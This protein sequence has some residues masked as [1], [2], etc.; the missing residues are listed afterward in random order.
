[1]G[2]FCKQRECWFGVG[3][4]GRSIELLFFYALLYTYS[5]LEEVG[6]E[7]DAPAALPLP[8]NGHNARLE[9]FEMGDF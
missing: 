1:V 5:A 7:F 9:N 8:P 6:A 4:G 3:E 2:D